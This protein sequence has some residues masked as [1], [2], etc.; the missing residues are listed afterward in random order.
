MK[1]LLLGDSTSFTGGFETATYPVY[2][3]NKTMWPEGSE[4]INPSVAGTT[5]A[6]AARYYSKFSKS[7]PHP[8]LTIV[9]LG[10]CDSC[11][12]LYPK[13]RHNFFG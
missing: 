1:I 11:S 5:S 3:A 7:N 9:N 13:G 4:L 2:L 12:T 10:N 8:E 6:D